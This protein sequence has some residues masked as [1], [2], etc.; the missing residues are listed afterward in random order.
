MIH[1]FIHAYTIDGESQRNNI[2]GEVQSKLGADTIDNATAHK[3]S[4]R[5]ERYEVNIIKKRKRAEEDKA[6]YDH[7]L[8]QGGSIV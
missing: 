2:L 3:S 4:K 5:H 1:I 6:F 7:T 8:K